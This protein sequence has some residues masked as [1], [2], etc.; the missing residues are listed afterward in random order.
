MCIISLFG[1]KYF[2]YML[3]ILINNIWYTY[4][5]LTLFSLLKDILKFWLFS[6]L[7]MD[8]LKK[9]IFFYNS[10]NFIFLSNL[11][12]FFWSCGKCVILPQGMQQQIKHL[13]LVWITACMSSL[14]LYAFPEF[15]C[16][17][18]SWKW[19]QLIRQ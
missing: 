17:C 2:L 4:C 9:K 18:W 16:S 19:L 10:I 15:I 7:I 12:I 11:P 6:V 13:M 3:I 8:I 14:F 5:F 1:M